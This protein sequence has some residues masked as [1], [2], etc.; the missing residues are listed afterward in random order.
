MAVES[1]F[2]TWLG[3]AAVI[4]AGWYVVH[5][6]TDRRDREKTRREVLIRITDA[7]SD[8]VDDILACAREYHSA[9]RNIGHELK[10]KMDLQDLG[11]RINGLSD[12]YADQAV[13]GLARSKLAAL[14]RAVTGVHFEDEHTGRL[15]ENSSQQLL[16]VEAVLDLKRTLLTIKNRQLQR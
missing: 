1:P 13:L 9:D 4:A 12:V 6:L 16:I 14:R 3:Q 8:D 11:I 2:L 15:A 5:K 7:L 10:L